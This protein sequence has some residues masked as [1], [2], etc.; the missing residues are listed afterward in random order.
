M[1]CPVRPARALRVALSTAL[2]AAA[3][4][5][6]TFAPLRACAQPTTADGN[7]KVDD[8]SAARGNV[9]DDG[10]FIV[11]KGGRPVRVEEFAIERMGDTLLVRAASM[12]SLPGQATRPVDKSMILIVGPYDFAMGSYW[13]RQ[14]AGTDTLRRGVEVSPGDT[15]YTIWRE[16]NRAGTGDRVAMPPGRLYILDPPLFTMF[17]FLGRTLNGKPCDRRPV[18]VFVLGFRDSLVNSTV[19]DA[20]TETI[21]WGSR[22]VQA[23]KLIITD[24]TTSFTGWYSPDDGRM[25]RLE[26][27]RDSIRVE[28]KAPPVKRQPPRTR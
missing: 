1:R 8:L 28:R 12:V 26:Q 20:G 16:F 5:V 7:N 17:N 27:A 9:L 2:A 6:L 25:F 21:R 18:Q 22:P 11:S 3:A 4:L 24:E 23:R 10:A 14:T 13:S 19:T 15:V